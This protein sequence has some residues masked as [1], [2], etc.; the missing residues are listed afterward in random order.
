MLDVAAS[1]IQSAEHDSN[2]VLD[3]LQS[4][5]TRTG[6]GIRS[7]VENWAGVVSRECNMLFGELTVQQ[8]KHIGEVSRIRFRY[9]SYR[10]VP[11]PF[12][13]LQAEKALQT[14]CSLL[15]IVVTESQSYIQEHVKAAISQ[16][17][18]LSTHTAENEVR[19]HL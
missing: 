8:E 4:S 5:L 17:H 10:S 3:V 16:M 1:K 7:A 6:D 2:N 13:M 11:N 15:E 12:A 18:T 9:I 14:A 19:V